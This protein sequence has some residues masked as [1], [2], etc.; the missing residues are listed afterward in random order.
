MA[1]KADICNLALSLLGDDASVASIEPPDGSPQAGNCARWYP[2]A[3]RQ[4]TEE[5]DWS[6]LTA[7]QQLAPLTNIDMTVYG[8]WKNAF[9][10]PSDCVRIIS[11]K[12]LS[13]NAC[14]WTTNP[15]EYEVEMN[16]TNGSRMLLC[17]SDSP[18][19]SFVRLNTNPSIYPT[20]FIRALVPLLASMLVGPLKRTDAASTMAQNLQQTYAAALSAAKTED[21]KNSIHHRGRLRVSSRLRIREV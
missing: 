17:N 1:T 16:P 3:L 21:C 10:V 9:S 14:W 18:V 8:F 5:F 4:L 12:E 6:F 19:I 2:L 13:P 15:L 20:Y 11:V 7:R